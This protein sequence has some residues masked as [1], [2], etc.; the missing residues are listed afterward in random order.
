MIDKEHNM[1]NNVSVKPYLY[2]VGSEAVPQWEDALVFNN[3]NETVNHPSEM[4]V[5]STVVGKAG[6]LRLIKDWKWKWAKVN[7]QRVS[8]CL[9]SNNQKGQGR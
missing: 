6:T 2:C 9:Y 7:Q 5:N 1:A 3:L 8:L 4:D